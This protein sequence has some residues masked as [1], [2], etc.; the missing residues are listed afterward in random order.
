MM[1]YVK[2]FMRDQNLKD[3]E[4][5]RILGEKDRIYKF[6]KDN[7]MV[8]YGSDVW[9]SNANDTLQKLLTG[10]Y[11]IVTPTTNLCKLLEVKPYQKFNVLAKDGTVI[12]QYVYID[13]YDIVCLNGS[14]MELYSLLG[15]LVLGYLK[16]E[17][18]K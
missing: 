10:E 4:I 7:L 3:G 17:I 9:Y 11:L 15:K 1:N 8:S 13:N 18:I 14:S 5:F 16:L 12:A 2:L 6:K